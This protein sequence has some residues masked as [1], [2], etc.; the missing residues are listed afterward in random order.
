MQLNKETEMPLHMAGR[1]TLRVHEERASGDLI[2]IQSLN[3]K[4]PEI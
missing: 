3:L 2:H 1:T 4:S